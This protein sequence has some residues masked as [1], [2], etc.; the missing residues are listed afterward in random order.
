MQ[1]SSITMTPPL[2]TLNPVLWLE[3]LERAALL[4]GPLIQALSILALVV[5]LYRPTRSNIRLVMMYVI[6]VVT[7]ASIVSQGPLYYAIQLAPVT[8]LIVAAAAGR[9]LPTRQNWRTAQ[10]SA[11]RVGL[12]VG[13]L[14]ILVL[15]NLSM[16]LANHTGDYNSAIQFV[17]RTVPAGKSIIGQQTYYLARPDEPYYSWEQ[18]VFYRRY[19]PGTN[20]EDAYRYLKPDYIIIDK[21]VE[22]FMTDD[23]TRQYENTAIS[24]FQMDAFLAKYGTLVARQNNPTYG[25]IRI[26]KIDQ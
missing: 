15:G 7:F 9:I 11:L 3:S 18:P 4:P 16:L 25:D 20:L 10:W 6:L 13:M 12:V 22:E 24:K 14:A 1:Q 23:P 26:Y 8:W 17:R 5:L 2:S 19:K 21:V